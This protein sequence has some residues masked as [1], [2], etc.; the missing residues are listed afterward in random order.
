MV[1]NR[2]RASI[3]EHLAG[4]N[5]PERMRILH[6]DDD[7]GFAE[8]AA[9]FLER[10]DDRFETVIA[11]SARDGLEIVATQR[12]D[13]IV[14][15][16]EMPG[17]NG[18]DFL[19]AVREN[20]GDLPFVLF[21]GKGSEAL[22]AEAIE[23]GV[24]S[25]QQKGSGTDQYALLAN[26]VRNHVEQYRE[27]IRADRLEEEYALV[28]EAAS[29]AFWVLDPA[30]ETLRW[31]GMQC[32]GY[33]AETVDSAFDWW[34]R[35]IHPNDRE[36]MR[37]FV[38]DLLA[39][40]EAAFDELTAERGRFSEEFR[41]RRADG[42]YAACSGRGILLCEGD[43][44]VKMV[45]TMTD[46]TDRRERERELEYRKDRFRAYVETATDILSVVDENGVSKFE[47]P[48]IERVLG[49]D[50]DDLVGVDNFQYIH[51]E[52]RERVR[53]VF[54]AMI[55]E[56]DVTTD[57]AE[58]RF[59][60]ADGGWVW[61]E[62]RGSNETHTAVNGYV[63]V[64]RDI[65][66][67]KQRERKLTRLQ[68]RIQRL[69]YTQTKEETAQVA[70][71]AANDI[72]DAPLSGV[73]LRDESEDAMTLV[74]VA[75]TVPDAF[76][77][78]LWYPRG[79]ES[80]SRAALLWEAFEDG[81]PLRIDDTHEYEPLTEETPTGSALIHPL[82]RHGVFIVSAE[83]PHAFDETD[84]TLVEILAM[85][86]TTA[87][88]RVERESELRARREELE[89]QNERLAELTDRLEEQYRHL[90]EEAPVMAVVTRNEDGTPV[91]EDCNRLFAETLGYD[92]DA[93]VGRELADF[94]T[95]ESRRALF[96]ED[97][98]ERALTGAFAREDRDLL[99]ADGEVVETVL[100]AV[101]RCDTAG[102]R[103]GTLALYIDIT[104][105]EQLK[106]EK[107]RLEEFTSIVSHDLRNPLNV[108][109]AR[110]ELAREEH[111]S[112]QLD[113]VA[114]AH[115]RMD[116]LIE[117][118]LTLA[119]SGRRVD[120]V[121]P[122]DIAELAGTCWRNVSTGEATLVTDV[123]RT[124]SADR[125]RLQQLLENLIRNAVEHSSTNPQAPEDARER[126]SE[127]VTV[128]VGELDDGA[129]FYVADDGPGIPESEREAVFG[130]GYSTADDGTGFGLSI[131]EEIA[132]AHDWDV[133]VTASDAD[134]ARFEITDVE[135]VR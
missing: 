85:S 39:R 18:I 104:E 89:R 14:S 118:L 92:R 125:S 61:L 83:E 20:H 26:R 55:K 63:L 43:A 73:H 51:P 62:T 34:T 29:D 38:D 57:K 113:A 60:H 9:E 13:C 1:T 17:M 4:G 131:V 45:G 93:V 50:P 102:E 32:F 22:A 67:R 126:A 135:F 80:G 115:D 110:L 59:R 10:A 116:A 84:E 65:T 96:D 3:D 23:A 6:V 30:T 46:I 114:Q 41:F 117:D 37:G 35:R 69:M 119:K 98:Y 5:S 53:D 120:E 88:D 19:D 40:E 91:V 66:E 123:D 56:P 103:D 68:R 130:S 105:R 95:S 48:A 49:Y 72:I 47:S 133:R 107:E 100:R 21:T 99:A 8:M 28:A 64:S 75:E 127:A 81:D 12:I 25:Y 122:V 15:D 24:D 71:D 79:A 108:A 109:H 128:S 70:T 106:R 111:D 112:D 36:R 94:Y 11:T 27:R 33:A 31:E 101:P 78:P 97:G 52:D 54:T 42:T 132:T 74:A 121:E 82:G 58:Y 86:L 2:N 77:E 134:G 44:P 129:G 16:Y 7:P 90:F 76:D 124:I 87:L